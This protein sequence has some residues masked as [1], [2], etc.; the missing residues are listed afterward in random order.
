MIGEATRSFQVMNPEL[1]IC[2][3]DSSAKLNI[4]LTIGKGRGYVPADD[5]KVKDA[6]FGYIAY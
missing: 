4:E 6:P 3:M 2:T 1:L 5:N